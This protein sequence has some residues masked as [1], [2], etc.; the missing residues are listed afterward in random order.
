VLPHRGDWQ[1]AELYAR[2]DELL[3]PLIAQRVPPTSRAEV[4]PAGRTL[5]VEGAVVS[6]VTRTGDE[7][8]LR[9]FNPATGSTRLTVEVDDE[10]AY[11]TIVD[12]RDEPIDAFN[13]QHEMR[14]GEIVTLRLH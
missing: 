11:G 1:S 7:L 10:P 8:T 4:A 5:R 2:A 9:A 6:A 13:G 3:L 12:L 14:G